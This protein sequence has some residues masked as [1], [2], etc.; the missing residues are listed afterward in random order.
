[1][2][3]LGIVF[4]SYTVIHAAS[5]IVV[6]NEVRGLLCFALLAIICLFLLAEGAE[7]G[8][9]SLDALLIGSFYEESHVK[10]GNLV[11]YRME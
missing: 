9:L 3:C 8:C 4:H 1:M 6:D 7:T 5:L 2:L 10:I 11:K